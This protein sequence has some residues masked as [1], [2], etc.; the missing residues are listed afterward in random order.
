VVITIGGVTVVGTHPSDEEIATRIREGQEAL[1]RALPAL[2]APGIKPREQWG[3]LFYR[4]HPRRQGVVIRDLDGKREIGSCEGGAFV[5]AEDDT[6]GR[7]H[8]TWKTPT[9]R[10]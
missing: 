2:C 9:T 10:G 5:V 7:T 6:A 1:A 8:D 3:I 4:A